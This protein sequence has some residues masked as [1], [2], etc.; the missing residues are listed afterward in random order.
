MS[1]QHN[2]A[3]LVV[4]RT[5]TNQDRKTVNWLC[6]ELKSG[7][8]RQGWGVPGMSVLNENGGPIGKF[9]WEANYREAAE[10][11]WGPNNRE[12]SQ[13]RY[14]ALAKMCHLRKGDIVV[15][16]KLP[17]W[18]QFSIARVTGEYYFADH[19]EQ[20]VRADFGHVI[21]VDADSVRIFNR[22]AND[23]AYLVWG[24]FSRANHRYPVTFAYAESHIKAAAELLRQESATAARSEDELIQTALDNALEHAAKAMLEKTRDWNWDKLEKA[25]RVA[26]ESR[27]FKIVPGY[28]RHDGKGADVD[29]VVSPQ[30]SFVH[31]QFMPEEIAVQVKWNQGIHGDDVKAVDQLIKWNEST[32]AQK[33]VISTADEFT[34]KCRKKAED[35]D[36]VLIGGL[37]AAYF[38]MG[39]PNFMRKDDTV[40]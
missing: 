20:D 23:D 30:T 2:P 26:F 17:K 29:L 3:H 13:R 25:V 16:P 35:N 32:V 15:I 8:L 28:R 11:A 22:H 38:L 9:Q 10:K 18:G 37:D 40:D 31:S 21:P 34:P 27:G 39:V 5:G 14:S 19:D 33:F 6:D 36:V 12:P 1:N 7:R 24:L 4:F